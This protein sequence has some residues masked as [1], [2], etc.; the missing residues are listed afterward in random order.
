MDGDKQ[1]RGKRK[2]KQQR[3]EY[4]HPVPLPY[5]LPRCKRCNRSQFDPYSG[6]TRGANDARS[7]YA[8][9]MVCGLK[10]RLI[11]K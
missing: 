10:H 7:Q 3:G 1:K 5:Q 2:R 9:C 6:V 11:G 8:K 4:E